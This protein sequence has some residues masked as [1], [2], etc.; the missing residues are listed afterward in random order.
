MTTTL[1]HTHTHT[2]KILS[3][4]YDTTVRIW[5]R[6]SGECIRILSGHEGSV[7]V[8]SLHNNILVTG[9]GDNTVGVWDWTTGR[10]KR[11]LRGHTDEVVQV[12]YIPLS[13]SSL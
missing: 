1:T 11:R 9:S 7:N 13:L 5:D 2:Q 3:C 8:M 6:Q 10:L 12:C 4:S